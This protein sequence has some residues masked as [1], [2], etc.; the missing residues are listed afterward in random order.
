MSQGAN[1]SGPSSNPPDTALAAYADFQ[2]ELQAI[3]QQ[4]V[5]DLSVRLAAE[6]GLPDLRLAVNDWTFTEGPKG[7]KKWTNKKTGHVVYGSENPGGKDRPASNGDEQHTSPS[8]PDQPSPEKQ[9]QIA[10]ILG[11][12]VPS[13]GRKVSKA[14]H[15]EYRQTITDHLKGLPDGAA[16]RVSSGLRSCQFYASQKTVSDAYEKAT[17]G[18]SKGMNVAGFASP[19]LGEVHLDNDDTPETRR[20]VYAHEMA[21]ILDWPGHGTP[22]S[23]TGEWES[24]WKSEIVERQRV[25]K[26]AAEDPREGFAEFWRMVDDFA[27]REGGRRTVEQAFPQCVE[28]MRQ[29]GI[30]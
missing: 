1:V 13:P 18:K 17:L 19:M 12:C 24:A 5:P 6:I 21:H 4:F 11:K 30:W 2:A 8:S 3:F 16:A 9:R 7:G 23:K 20:G 22:I 15:E 14:L 28:V 10:S 26:Y 29:Q 27:H 25:S